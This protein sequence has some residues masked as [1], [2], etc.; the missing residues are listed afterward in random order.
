M[1]VVEDEFLIAMV[2]EEMLA[3]LECIV[4][5]PFSR[6]SPA[7]AAAASETIDV[8]LLDVN[9]AGE[10]VFPVAEA[11]EARGIPF[12][13]VTGY[14]NLAIPPDRPDWEAC[15]K[16][17]QFDDLIERLARKVIVE[18]TAPVDTAQP[19]GHAAVIPTAAG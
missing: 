17:F 5:G 2:I 19:P 3:E 9:V 1:L 15:S 13:F 16:P 7:L 18:P 11:L 6:V 12:L 10:K 14:G 8:A 4:V